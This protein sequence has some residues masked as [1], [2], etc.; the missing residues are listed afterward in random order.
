MRVWLVFLFLVGFVS[1]SVHISSYDV[2]DEYV[3]S[4]YV[5]GSVNLTIR[6]EFYDENISLSDGR[7]VGL[8]DFLMDNG[9]DFNCSPVDCSMGYSALPGGTLKTVLVGPGEEKY[10]GFVL[11]GDDIFLD[12]IYFRVSSD[13][14]REGDLPLVVE[15]FELEEWKFS[16]FSNEFLPKNWGCFNPVNK[17]VGPLIGNSFYCE[18]ITVKDSKTLRVG[19]DVYGTGGNLTMNVYPESGFG[20]S[21]ECSFNPSVSDGCVLDLDADEMVDA[22]K[23]QVCVGASSLTGYNIYDDVSGDV[24]GFTYNNGPGESVKDYGI[25]AQRVKYADAS[26]MGELDF[27][28]KADLAN[29]FISDRYNG[30]CSDG[31][32][33]P[34]KISGAEQNFS[35]YDVGITYTD[36]S[37]WRS[38]N[39][40]HEIEGVSAL[41][42]FNGTLNIGFF[43]IPVLAAG[44]YFAQ[45]SGV[46]FFRKNI[47]L[48]P[49]PIILS[50]SPTKAPAGVPVTFYTNID[51]D[52]NKSLKYEWDFGD[53]GGIETNTPYASHAYNDLTN[54]TLSLKVSAGGN[55]TSEKEFRIDVISPEEAIDSGLRERRSALVKVR[56]MVRALSSWYES[57]LVKILELDVL[58]SELDRL[59][60]ARNNSFDVEDFRDVAVELYALNVPV[61]VG[62]NRYESPFLMTELKDVDVDAVA[63]ISGG[64]VGGSETAY[65]NS[66]IVWQNQN[67][68]VLLKTRDIFVSYWDGSD[69]DVLSSYSVEVTSGWDRE[70]YFI[71]NKPFSELYFKGA[72]GAR[73]AGDSS[74]IVLAPRESKSFEFYHKGKSIGGFFVSPRLSELIIEEDIDLTCNFNFICD[75]ENGETPDNCRT[76]CKPVAKAIFFLI[77]GFLFFLVI[78]TAL[79][80]WYK[81]HYEAYLFRDNAQLYNLLMFISN[82]RARGV[83]DKKIAS[84]LISKG[85]SKERV[86]YVVKKSLGKTVGMI[87]IIPIEKVA[88][89]LRDRRA[90][91]N[92]AAGKKPQAVSQSGVPPRTRGLQRL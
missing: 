64:S 54:Y 30:D 79:Q 70:S 38:S 19:A 16:N 69:A 11:T 3:F 10:V 88:A 48:L 73:K 42:D 83:N 40:V 27:S 52:G 37:E 47:K 35:I 6:D 26:A 34:L 82:A 77:I 50:V 2:A 78:Y 25:F 84:D 15:F 66:I 7:S 39:M 53:G 67:V 72:S 14:G 32:I 74:V 63:A 49:A 18:M 28:D 86:D 12:S 92:L 23:Y 21:W 76:D 57:D 62:E 1:A 45:I 71:I 85:W 46:D 80:V 17:R 60:R 90:R 89:F 41:V 31:C 87:E 24:C 91:K 9:A 36:N 65:T 33:L 55:L 75:E 68:N 29:L 43:E 44:E 22:G 61:V 5:S 51:F 56:E 13:F 59:D 81:R 4:D 20:T 8:G 58:E